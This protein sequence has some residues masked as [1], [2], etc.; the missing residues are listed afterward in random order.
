MLRGADSRLLHP[1]ISSVEM[2]II[3]MEKHLYVWIRSTYRQ[4]ENIVALL[5]LFFWPGGGG[6]GAL[7]MLICS[8]DKNDDVNNEKT[9]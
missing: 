2:T 5:P 4:G 3:Q 7:D 9:S 6:G 8:E 1:R